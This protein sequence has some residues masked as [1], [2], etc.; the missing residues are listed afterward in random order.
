MS[1][2]TFQADI[3]GDLQKSVIVLLWATRIFDDEDW[4]GEFDGRKDCND[5]FDDVPGTMA[6]RF[7]Q[8]W[9]CGFVNQGDLKLIFWKLSSDKVRE[10]P[11]KKKNV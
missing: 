5:V 11:P 3:D 2:I 6:S 8:L 7:V 10:A 9:K 1:I 4:D